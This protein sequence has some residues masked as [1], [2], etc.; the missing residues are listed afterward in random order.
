M[1]AAHGICFVGPD[2]FPP[3]GCVVVQVPDGYGMTDE[4]LVALRQAFEPWN[5]LLFDFLGE[6]FDW[7]SKS[8]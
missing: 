2:F 7:N 6:D 3:V 5:A 1:V 4:T 8:A